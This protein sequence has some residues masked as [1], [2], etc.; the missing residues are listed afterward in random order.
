MKFRVGQGIDFHKLSLKQDNPKPLILGGIEIDSEYSIIAHSD[1][2]ILLHSLADAILGALGESDIGEFFP[3]DKE[4]T[5]NIDSKIILQKAL[6][7]AK[8]K[9]YFI[10]NI[11]ITIISEVPKIKPYREKIKES[12][13]KLC[14]ISQTNIAIKATTT[15]KMGFIGK[16]EGIACIATILL[17]RR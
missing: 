6:E 8:E 16:K 14:N 12:I 3:D 13:S 7:L 10:S 15:E 11:D 9:N 5:K 2:D 4:E 17:E 1:G